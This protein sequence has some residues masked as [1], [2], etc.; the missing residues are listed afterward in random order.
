MAE[1]DPAPVVLFVF[2][3]PHHLKKTL[4]SLLQNS[5]AGT[6]DLFV[7]SD[8]PRCDEDLQAV[9]DVREIVHSITGFSSVTITERDHNFGLARSVISGTSEVMKCFDR[10]ICVEDDLIVTKH[11]LE[12]MNSALC[13]YRD[14]PVFS[15][16]GYNFPRERFVLDV[17][18]PYDTYAVPRCGSWGWATWK[19]R[20]NT[21]DWEMKYFK[22][23]M[24]SSAK[25]RLFNQGGADLVDML[26]AQRNGKVDSWAIRFCH[27]A[28]MAKLACIYPIE[29]LVENI[30][31]DGS[32]RHTGPDLRRV[33]GNLNDGFLPQ[34][35]APA[36]IRED[37]AETFRRAC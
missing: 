14:E 29:S 11:F 19:D 3:R 15:I 34:A 2:N 6:S 7:F 9:T 20:W 28:A 22:S 37:I 27:A 13:F 31:L 17:D 21:V 8:G 30:G 35:M 24:C 18:Y 32:G 36:K 23:F 26:R 4:D 12:F 25:R 10:V 1:L 16:S 5:F 33:H